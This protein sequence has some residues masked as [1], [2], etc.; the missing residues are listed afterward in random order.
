MQL[1]IIKDLVVV[2]VDSY[3]GLLK[4]KIRAEIVFVL[5]FQDKSKACDGETSGGGFFYLLFIDR[6]Q[7]VNDPVFGL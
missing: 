6:L 4:R 7:G 3:E 1:L 2:V 5:F